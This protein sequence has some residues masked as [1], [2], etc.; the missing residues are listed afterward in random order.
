MPINIWESADLYYQS[1]M[2]KESH[3]L[4]YIWL[5]SFLKKSENSKDW[6]G[7]GKKEES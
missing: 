4:L 6:W 7:Y 3:A 2:S 1:E 5:E